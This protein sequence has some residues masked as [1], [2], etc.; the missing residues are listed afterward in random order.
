MKHGTVKIDED[1]CLKHKEP[2]QQTT[3]D[4]GNYLSPLIHNTM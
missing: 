1:F 4:P 2:K 3:F